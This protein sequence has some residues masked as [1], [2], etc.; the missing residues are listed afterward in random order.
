[1]NLVNS[2]FRP[3]IDLILLPFSGMPAIVG[4]AVLSCLFGAVVLLIYKW[5][6]NQEAI[7]EVKEEIAAGI[8]EMRLFNDDIGALFRAQ[9]GLM[10]ANARYLALNLWPVLVMTVLFLPVFMQLFFHYQFQP[11]RPG[12]STVL[13][14]KLEPNA[15]S[16]PVLDLPDGLRAGSPKVAVDALDEVSWRLVGEREGDYAVTV[17]VGDESATKALVVTENAVKRISPL[18]L[19]PGLVNAFLAPGEKALPGNSPIQRLEVHYE[20]AEV[21]S[22]VTRVNWAIPFIVIS[23][24]FAFAFRKRFGVTI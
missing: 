11:L 19:K 9:F 2:L 24:A 3:L 18:R 16:P 1:M 15:E 14:A 22:L 12:Q 17:R 5:I 13:T 23:I 8:Y 6:S 21:D 10:A 4:L 20:T 7:A